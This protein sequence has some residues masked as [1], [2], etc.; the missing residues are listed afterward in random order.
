MAGDQAMD[1]P[2]WR[3]FMA[4]TSRF[5]LDSG[6]FDAMIDGQVEDLDFRQPETMDELVEYCRKVASSV[7]RVCISIWGY[8]DPKALELAD[9]RG[10][11]FQ[12]TNVLRDVREDHSNGR[13]YIP[14]SILEKSGLEIDTLLKW[15]HPD[16]C[17][18]LIRSLVKASESRYRSSAPLDSMITRSCRPTLRAMTRIYH[19]ILQR[20]NR[21]PRSIAGPR[22]VKLG[23]LR[24]FTIALTA[25]LQAGAS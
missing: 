11:A 14:R 5:G 25:R 2:M 12:L 6:P 3:A 15:E 10:I 4:T 9:E 8:D 23:G 16:R 20:M 7:G 18:E 19:G 21:N 13:V 17:D 24:K 1:D 22:R